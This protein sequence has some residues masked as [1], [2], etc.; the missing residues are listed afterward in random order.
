M[1]CHFEGYEQGYFKINPFFNWKKGAVLN[2][3]VWLDIF[4]LFEF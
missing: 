2:Y 1:V 4:P 3:Q